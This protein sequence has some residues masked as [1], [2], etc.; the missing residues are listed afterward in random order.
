MIETDHA[1]DA[2]FNKNFFTDFLKVLKKSP[3]VSS[4]SV[5]IQYISFLTLVIVSDWRPEDREI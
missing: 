1:Q 2:T 5:G 3:P 4:T